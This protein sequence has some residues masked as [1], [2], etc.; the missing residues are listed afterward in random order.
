MLFRSQ[1]NGIGCVPLRRS[2][3][4]DPGF[5]FLLW[6]SRVQ[7]FLHC[8]VEQA[9]KGLRILQHHK[10]PDARHPHDLN[11]MTLRRLP[12]RPAITRVDRYLGRFDPLEPLLEL[13]IMP[14]EFFK[15]TDTNVGRGRRH[16]DRKSTRL[17]SSHIQKSRMPSSA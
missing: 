15:S 9:V 4:P 8:F 1:D 13:A 14:P 16:Q 12:I 11:P 2:G 10:V 3:E 7:T 6:R 17:N 5:L